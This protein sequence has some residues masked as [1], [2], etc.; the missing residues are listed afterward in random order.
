MTNWPSREEWADR[1]RHPYWDGE[2]GCPFADKFGHRLSDYATTEEIAALIA[3]LKNLYRDMG[4][5]M[6][7]AKQLAAERGLPSDWLSF[8]HLP[9]AEQEIAARPET[10]KYER[11]DINRLLAV[12]RDDAY[13]A[14]PPQFGYSGDAAR[15]L[16]QPFVDRHDA[17]FK[18][19]LAEWE[20]EREQISVDDAAWAEEL[21]RRRD[22]DAYLTNDWRSPPSSTGS[23]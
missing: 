20:R 18:T 8:R 11:H 14:F 2:T 17:A 21:E 1:R 13:D 23:C 4:R 9:E 16:M 6:R 7:T 15:A 12:I 3:T 5:E 19:A 10:L 22:I